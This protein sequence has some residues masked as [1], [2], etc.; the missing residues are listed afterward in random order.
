MVGD[1]LI[2]YERDDLFQEDI[3][4]LPIDKFALHTIGNTLC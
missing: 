3:D 2:N 4:Q 1:I